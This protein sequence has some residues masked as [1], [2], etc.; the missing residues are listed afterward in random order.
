[1]AKIK[2]QIWGY[3]C[4]RC[5]HEWIPHD[6]TPR[7][8][9]KCKS[10]YWDR[11]RKSENPTDA[12]LQNIVRTH[13][14]FLINTLGRYSVEGRSIPL[15]VNHRPEEILSAGF[16]LPPTLRGK[17]TIH[18][19]FSI[20]V[21]PTVKN[22]I[23]EINLLRKPDELGPLPSGVVCEAVDAKAIPPTYRVILHTP[24]VEDHPIAPDP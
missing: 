1:M 9:P 11:P 8:C 2:L 5:G 13:G 6:Q 18:G 14:V 7:I 4:E 15:N 20:G 21:K 17:I 3:R 24:S 22:A 12:V 19:S 23:E 10:P 16:K